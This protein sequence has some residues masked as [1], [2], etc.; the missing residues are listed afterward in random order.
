MVHGRY[1]SD[2]ELRARYRFGRESIYNIVR[3]VEDDIRPSANRTFPISAT[4]QVLITLRFLATGSFLQVVGDTIA[5]VDKATVS[6]VVRRVTLLIA[7]KLDNYVKFP[8]TQ[9]EKDIIKQGFYD[10]G[11]FPCVVGCVDGSHVI[12]IAPADNEPDFVNR[13][14]YHSINIQGI[15]DHKGKLLN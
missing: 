9:Q 14:G 3:L 2:S 15:C 6:R 11:G 1:Y 12:I 13:K 10:L 7:A 8:Q 4:N 5:G